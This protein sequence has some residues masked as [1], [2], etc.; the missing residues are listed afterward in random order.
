MKNINTT[1]TFQ[2]YIDS[3]A[4]E[5]QRLLGIQ[6]NEY[7]PNY[8]V[9]I[10]ETNWW[11]DQDGGKPGLA[12]IF[13]DDTRLGVGTYFSIGESEFDNNIHDPEFLDRLAQTRLI[14]A[15]LS[16]RENHELLIKK[17]GEQ[18]WTRN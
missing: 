16:L 5:I 9:K 18:E 7:E 3:I 15:V 17:L 1:G 6:I 2:E 13:S 14:G 11:V 10:E 12:I 4:A 8:I